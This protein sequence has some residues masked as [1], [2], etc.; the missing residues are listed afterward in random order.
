VLAEAEV[1]HVFSSAGDPALF[2][3]RLTKQA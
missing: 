3:G 1:R 2:T